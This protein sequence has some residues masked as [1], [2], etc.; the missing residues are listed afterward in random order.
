MIQIDDAGNGAVLGGEVIGALRVETG[1]YVSKVLPLTAY[2]FFEI[3]RVHAAKRAVLKLLDHL[4]PG[5]EEEILICTGDIFKE[6]KTYLS[7]H[8]IN[9]R[10]EKI[11]GTLQELV[12]A[13]FFNSLRSYGLP[14]R[15][16]AFHNNYPRFHNL[17]FNWVCQ[18]LA[19]RAKYCK[20]LRLN[21]SL[22][23]R[24]KIYKTLP[25]KTYTCGLCQ[26]PIAPDCEA[27]V[28][29]HEEQPLYFHPECFPA[30]VDLCDYLEST[31]QGQ[32]IRCFINTAPTLPLCVVCQQKIKYKKRLIKFQDQVYHFNCF[33]QRL[34]EA[35]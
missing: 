30:D 27:V 29:K 8:G 18:D 24:A 35:F 19:R 22:V 34:G 20:P 28:D 4:N 2:A 12:E 6:T 23:A 13:S 16:R 31:L 25:Q 11:T 3:P 26:Q 32:V 7:E 15:F 33:A 1:E 9:W 17:V 10:E 5:H 14:E 21:S